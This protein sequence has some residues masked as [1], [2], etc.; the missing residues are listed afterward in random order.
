[1]LSD[2]NQ[3]CRVCGY[4]AETPPWGEDGKSPTYEICP[5]CGVEYGYEDS[6]IIAAK[7]YRQDWIASGAKWN[8]VNEKPANWLLED[9]LHHIPADFR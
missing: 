3:R 9:Q 7:N 1:M 4:L 6:T 8:D 5:C 2:D